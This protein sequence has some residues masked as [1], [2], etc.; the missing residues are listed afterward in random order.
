MK[1]L[2]FIISHCFDPQWKPNMVILRDYMQSIDGEVE[3][4]AISSQND[5]V[6]YNDVIPYKYTVVN[7]L[8]QI[9]K[10]HDF[11]GKYHP[12]L[13]YDW[14]IKTRPDIKMLEPL[15]FDW[16]NP[17]A[18]NARARVYK[19]PKAIPY[20]MSVNGPHDIFSNIKDS[21]AKEAL[22]TEVVLDDQFFVFS[23]KVVAAGAFR[24][25]IVLPNVCSNEWVQSDIFK[26]RNI[27]LNVIGMQLELT[28][29]KTFSGHLNCN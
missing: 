24:P 20:G 29:H 13:Q 12:C 5:F 7:P 16:L 28:K 22:E 25:V 10:L 26:A 11:V 8:C 21:V 4:C 27:P 9:R 15:R 18:I 6:A 14:F 17:N 3:Y 23:H 1:V 2:V 19:G